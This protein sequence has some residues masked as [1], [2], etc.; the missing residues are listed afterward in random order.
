MHAATEREFCSSR[1]YSRVLLVDNT[2]G[3]C[4]LRVSRTLQQV[5]YGAVGEC[6]SGRTVS[7][8]FM[9]VSNNWVN[10]EK[11]LVS[12]DGIAQ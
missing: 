1:Q 10:I 12:G 5:S 3:D 2:T 9:M 7:V 8:F 4:F 11:K 6:Q